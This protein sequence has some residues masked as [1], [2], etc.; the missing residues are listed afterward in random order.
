MG[1]YFIK[2]M[3]MSRPLHQAMYV[4]KIITKVWGRL[5][6]P[7]SKHNQTA[8]QNVWDIAKKFLIDLTFC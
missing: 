2:Q 5:R 8:I 3:K 4:T 6:R 7:Q 1:V